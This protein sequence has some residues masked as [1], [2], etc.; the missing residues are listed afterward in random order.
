MRSPK[1]ANS[2]EEIPS[3]DPNSVLR[4]VSSVNISGTV[5]GATSA[6]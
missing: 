1:K 5:V 3:S 2:S 6:V 4:S